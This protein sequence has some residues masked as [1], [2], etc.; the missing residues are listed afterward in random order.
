MTV[1]LCFRPVRGIVVNTLTV[2]EITLVTIQ[3]D[4]TPGDTRKYESSRSKMTSGKD[5]FCL[6]SNNLNVR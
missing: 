6:R 4:S 2:T 5:A 1:G 3:Q